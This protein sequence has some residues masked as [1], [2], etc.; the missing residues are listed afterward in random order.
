M[1]RPPLPFLFSSLMAHV[2]KAKF[3]ADHWLKINFTSRKMQLNLLV[4][5]YLSGVLR[6]RTVGVELINIP[7]DDKHNSS[8]IV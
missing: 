2:P 3:C 7:N 5:Q 1:R 4:F 8:F 6:D